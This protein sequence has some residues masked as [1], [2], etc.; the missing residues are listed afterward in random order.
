MSLPPEAELYPAESIDDHLLRLGIED[1]LWYEAD[2]LDDNQLD[3]WLDLFTE[4][5][6]YWMPIRRNVA[7][8]QMDTEMTAEGPDLSW[9][10]DDK[11]TLRQRV[12]QLKTGYHWAE[13]PFS[14][15]THMISNIRV[16]AWDGHEAKVRSRFLFYRNRHAD[17]ESVFIGKRVDTLRLVDGAWKI[18][19]REVYLDESVLLFKNLTNFF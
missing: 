3:E 15:I 13:E 17:E 2:L 18:A 12:E 7:S 19:R 4:D 14:R 6:F 1:F 16:L 10:S 8:R 11:P 5:T 9:F